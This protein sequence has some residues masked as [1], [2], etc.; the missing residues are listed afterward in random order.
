MSLTEFDK[1]LSINKLN[2]IINKKSARGMGDLIITFFAYN[3][4]IL[5]I[6]LTKILLGY[7][8]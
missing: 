1:I 2:K 3:R 7:N 8:L 6:L 5:L 4:Q